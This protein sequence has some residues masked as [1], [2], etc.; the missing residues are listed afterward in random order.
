MD[1]CVKVKPNLNV[2]RNDEYYSSRHCVHCHFLWIFFV[3]HF[4]TRQCTR[5]FVCNLAAWWN[6]HVIHNSFHAEIM[7]HLNS[8]TLTV[9][10]S[11]RNRGTKE[12]NNQQI[13]LSVRNFNNIV[14][15]VAVDRCKE[16]NQCSIMHQNNNDD[17]NDRLITTIKLLQFLFCY[18]MYHR[19]VAY[20]SFVVC[21][22]C[23]FLLRVHFADMIWVIWLVNACFLRSN[24]V[25]IDVSAFC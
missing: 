8:I 10:Y 15:A 22:E 25:M 12:R 21:I 23:S 4:I 2:K 14:D 13:W 20:F 9:V 16:V 19:L 1:A 24:S 5:W 7:G 18:Y 11:W 17:S 6:L 3:F